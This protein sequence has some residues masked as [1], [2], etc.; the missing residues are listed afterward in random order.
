MRIVLAIKESSYG[1]WCISNGKALV[2]DKLRFAYAIRLGRALSRAGHERKGDTVGVEM[3]CSEFT[4]TLLNFALATTAR[5]ATNGQAEAW[6]DQGKLSAAERNPGASLVRI[7][8][9]PL[10]A[11]SA[12]R[13]RALS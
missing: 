10:V 7:T 11:G 4:I 8:P 12:T 1:L 9:R 6:R 3:D 2:H 13:L 5:H